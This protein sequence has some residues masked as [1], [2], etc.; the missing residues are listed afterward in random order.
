MHKTAAEAVAYFSDKLG[1]TMAA[2][3]LKEIL[4]SGDSSYVVIDARHSDA[5]GEGHVPGATFVDTDQPLEQWNLGDKEKTYVFYCYS[6]Y[7][8]R[9]ARACLAAA[10]EG[11]KVMELHG[12]FEV[13]EGYPMPVEK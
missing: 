12:G 6:E 1:F 13:W 9:A 4:D 5:F 8:H 2:S 10:L 11:Y 7:C 3:R